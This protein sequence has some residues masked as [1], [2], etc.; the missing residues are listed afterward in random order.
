MAKGARRVLFTAVGTRRGAAATNENTL[1][2][3]RPPVLTRRS[4]GLA[5]RR[6]L[7]MDVGGAC[8]LAH[9]PLSDRVPSRASLSAS[10]NTRNTPGTPENTAK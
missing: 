7:D 3:E 5:W 4:P 6:G 9:R 8:A 1:R 2:P 10:P